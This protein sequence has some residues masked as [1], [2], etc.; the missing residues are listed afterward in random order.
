MIKLVL[1]ILPVAAAAALTAYLVANRPGPEK[2]PRGEEVRTLRVIKAPAPDLVPRATGYGVAEPG[3]VWEAV[4]EVKGTV[5]EVHPRLSS[6]ELIRGDSVLVRL[7]PAEYEL[8]IARLE[9]ALEET[10]AKIK[11]LSGEAE[12][13]ERLLAVERRSLDL[14]RKSFDRKRTQAQRGVMSQ[15]EADREERAFL[16]QQQKVRELENTLSLIPSRRRALNAALA[17]H[18]ADLERARLD[19]SKTTIRAPFDCRLGEVKIEPG[20][21]LRAG[22]TLFKAHGTSV[23]EVEARFRAE[24]MRN[25]LGEEKRR[26]FQT[27]VGIETFARIFEDMKV[28]VRLESGEWSAE[29]EARIDRVREETDPGTRDVKVIAA[30]DRP[31]EKA[32]PGERPPLTA[33]MFCEVEIR[34]PARPGSIILPRS[35]VHTGGVF[36]LDR[37]QRLRKR[38]VVVDFAQGDFVVILSGLEGGETVVVSDPSPAIIGMKVSPVLD[39]DLLQRLLAQGRGGEGT[40]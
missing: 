21:F 14:A 31:Y 30:V 23:T 20:Q 22:Q 25:L 34:A 33:G 35:S 8:A 1:T 5:A 36:V 29:W 2:K 38:E 17:V 16:Q 9:A 4:A 7:D 32:V 13:I 3:E 28:L 26:R 40:P 39:E 19:L 15:D 6:G 37:E 24:Q 10:R 11:E 27:G 18:E 12:N